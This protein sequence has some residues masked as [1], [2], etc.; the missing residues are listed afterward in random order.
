MIIIGLLITGILKGQEMIANAQITSSISQLK[1]L[2]ASISTFR[3]KYRSLPG[4]MPNSNT[5]LA[6]CV[7]APCATGPAAGALGDG[8]INVPAGVAVPAAVANEN[9]LAFVHLAAADLISG[10]A[11]TAP[12]L[13]FGSALPSA[14]I[15]GGYW[16]GYSAGGAIAGL[17]GTNVRPGHYLILN[18]L[19]AAPGAVNG[20]VNGAQ[21]L[22]IDNKLDDGTPLTGAVQ[23]GGTVCIDTAQYDADNSAA[24]CTMAVRVQG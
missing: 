4:D 11:V 10:V 15:G 2:D 7:A 14:N 22:Q 12:T 19:V 18:G 21:A 23:A 13:T 9:A 17:A 20:V 6:N 24:L 3:D 16:V 5:R 8:R 1:G